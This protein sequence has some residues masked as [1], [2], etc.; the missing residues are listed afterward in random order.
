VRFL[1]RIRI[2]RRTR[3][4]SLPVFIRQSVAADWGIGVGL[5]VAIL[6]WMAGISG[7]VYLFLIA[8]GQFTVPALVVAVWG[9]W[10][11]GGI[12]AM[13]A[14]VAALPRFWTRRWEICVADGS[15][16]RTWMATADVPTVPWDF[17]W[18]MSG[19]VV[20]VAEVSPDGLERPFTPFLAPPSISGFD[21]YAA[22]RK[23][24]FEELATIAGMNWAK[25]QAGVL[26]GIIAVS[27]F[28]GYIV[29]FGGNGNA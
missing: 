17:K 3:G 13:P 26:L 15:C 23:T 11:I 24:P 27:L 21:V 1:N 9:G 16:L 19:R 20:V 5:A 25:V 14:L 8:P 7:G 6:A 2:P 12:V 29:V 18:I 4:R 22:V 28:F 10:F